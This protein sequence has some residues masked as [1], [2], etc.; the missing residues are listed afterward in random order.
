M[1]SLDYGREFW[2]SAGRIKTADTKH[3]LRPVLL[4]SRQRPRPASGLADS[5]SFCQVRFASAQLVLCTPAHRGVVRRHQSPRLSVELEIV[6]KHQQLERIASPV[7][8]L[9]LDAAN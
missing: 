8:C 9:Y 7:S 1:N 2:W 5:F 4:V 3:L 6:E